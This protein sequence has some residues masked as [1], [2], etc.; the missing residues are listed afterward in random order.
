MPDDHTFIAKVLQKQARGFKQ[1][2]NN[3][4]ALTK[5]I[6]IMDV[7]PNIDNYYITD[8]ADG[9]RAFLVSKN[10]KW[11]YLSGETAG[12]LGKSTLNDT[13]LDCELVDDIFYIFDIILMDGIYVWKM[14]FETR[15]SKLNTLKKTL[16]SMESSKED[17]ATLEKIKFK[18]YRRLTTKT[19]QNEIF[20]LYKTTRPYVTD[21]IIFTDKSNDYHKTKNLKWKPPEHLTID[22]LAIEL[23]PGEILLLSG[24]D[25]NTFK[26]FGM[27]LPSRYTD[28]I[29]KVPDLTLNI[30]HGKLYDKYFPVPFEGSLLSGTS[31]MKYKNSNAISGKIIEVSWQ[32]QD[33]HDS[34]WKFHRVRDDRASEIKTKTYFG[35]NFK[36]AEM[37]LQ[38][39]LNP[40]TINDIVAPYANLIKKVYFQKSD[41]TYR[42]VRKFN[43]YVKDL[44][45][46]MYKAPQVLDLASGKGQDLYKYMNA[47]Y[48]II[49]MLEKDQNAIE[50]ILQLK[51]EVLGVKKYIPNINDPILLCSPNDTESI[52]EYGCQI[53]IRNIDLNENYTTNIKILEDL[54][55]ATQKFP[56]IFCNFALHY[57]MADEISMANIVSFIDH[58]LGNGGVFIFTALDGE[59]V[60]DFVKNNAY[61]VPG[62][63]M[64]E[65]Q[66]KP[67]KGFAGFEK[68]NVQLP[69]GAE[70][71][72]EPLINLYTL[73]KEFNKKKITR[74]STGSFGDYFDDF[75]E[76]SRNAYENLNTDDKFFVSLY[77]YAVYERL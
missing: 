27:Q 2:G 28:Y 51:Y 1:L 11:T 39:S 74:I 36:I 43:N 6:Y 35:N 33:T 19:Y 20:T 62:K 30:S 8:K 23:T 22:F 63:Y 24:I 42:Y 14:P 77:K 58:Y 21:G 56:V 48:K 9:I 31:K 38:A 12:I 5:S 47:D 18:E 34:M 67:I 64:I 70:I 15:F 4:H 13:I 3:P 16:E 57:M 26:R 61:K 71:Y 45:I 76:A 54:P 40:L 75:A 25:R 29:A 53:Y 17:T 72:E 73:D 60:Y 37:T 59:K 44:L 49:I 46:K 66:K 52:P 65:L 32:N 50:K 7:L 69:C 55:V 68:I 41:D 10:G